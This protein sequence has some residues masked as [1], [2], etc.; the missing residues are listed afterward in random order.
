MAKIRIIDAATCV[1][2]RAFSQIMIFVCL[3]KFVSNYEFNDKNVNV[4]TVKYFINKKY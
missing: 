3:L 1:I 2:W 4:F